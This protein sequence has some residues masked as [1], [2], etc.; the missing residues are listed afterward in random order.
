MNTS[1][2]A[3][4]KRKKNTSQ[5]LEAIVMVHFGCPMISRSEGRG[6]LA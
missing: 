3:D 1:A 5:F 2:Q 6:M 4:E